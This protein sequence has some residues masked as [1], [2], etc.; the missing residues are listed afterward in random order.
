MPSTVVRW[1]NEAQGGGR[2]SSFLRNDAVFVMRACCLSTTDLNGSGRTRKAF[3]SFIGMAD[4][5]STF[6]T[7]CEYYEAVLT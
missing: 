4:L 5:D 6:P 2:H 3:I 1:N 7:P